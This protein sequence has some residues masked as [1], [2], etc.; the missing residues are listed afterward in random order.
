MIFGK[1]KKTFPEFADLR[2]LS[3][4]KRICCHDSHLTEHQIYIL[5][6]ISSSLKIE[7]NRLGVGLVL[8]SL[9]LSVSESELS[10]TLD[11]MHNFVTELRFPSLEQV[12][13][14]V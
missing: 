12:M 3:V 13:V 8:L 4:K 10:L 11:N 1:L 5:F 9:S 2:K 14:A 6:G 7:I